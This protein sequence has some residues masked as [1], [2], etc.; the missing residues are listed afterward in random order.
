MHPLTQIISAERLAQILADF[1]DKRIGVIGDIALDAYWEADMTRSVLSRETPHHPY[2][3]TR[4]RY[5]PGAGGTVAINLSALGVG[6]VTVFSIFGDDWRGETL[7]H[8]LSGRGVD[9]T[10]IITAPKRVTPAYI[11]PILMGFD[12][13][14]EAARLDFENTAPLPQN[15]EADLMRRV[16]QQL[17][18][19]DALLIAD[20][21][22]VNGIITDSVREKLIE[23]AANNPEKIIAVDSRHK[24]GAF[25]SMVLKANISETLAA[26]EQK[27]TSSKISSEKITDIGKTLTR[28]NKAPLFITAGDDGVFA[29]D[30]GTARHI[31]P[32]PVQ[33]PLDIVGAG[34]SFFAASS[35]ALSTGAS[36]WTA[37]AI[38][39]LAAAISVEKLM[40]TGTASPQEIMARYQKMM[41]ET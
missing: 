32:A 26:F 12:S 34:D 29:F 1:A 31:P 24:I 18:H 14:Q 40:Q 23:L 17:P 37:A 4:E 15:L 3:I 33:P 7:R 41:R 30:G 28:Q 38:G 6:A 36:A 11:K 22:S 9:T 2:P 27:N 13:Q 35:A 21:F 8:A 39:N 25:H 5:A 16:T 19:L 10:E 20:Q